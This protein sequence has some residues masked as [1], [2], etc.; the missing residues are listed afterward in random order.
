MKILNIIEIFL[1]ASNLVKAFASSTTP[2][3]A[4]A[5]PTTIH[6]NENGLTH[7]VGVLFKPEANPG[8]SITANFGHESKLL[9]DVI[10][11][12]TFEHWLKERLNE[13]RT[14]V[15]EK[16]KKLPPDQNIRWFE[17]S[18]PKQSFR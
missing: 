18:Y 12:H 9:K 13:R 17:W 3:G 15:L 11:S 6:Q 14:E 5:T 16:L 2:E 4:T 10:L 8:D 7:N 1:N